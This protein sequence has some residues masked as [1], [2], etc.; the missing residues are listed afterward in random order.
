MAHR[1]QLVLGVALAMLAVTRPA[2][3]APPALAPSMIGEPPQGG[4]VFRFPQAVAL[5]PGGGTVWI[6]DE[7][8]GVVQS[9]D[10]TGTPRMT[11]GARATRGERGRFGVIG[12]LATDRSGRV[13]VLDAE[14]DRV[15]VL[16]GADGRVLAS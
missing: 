13:Y 2:A 9:F 3:A 7:Y 1:W 5:S 15:Q 4:A 16:S 11:V 14:N 8:S 10:A 12:G 6:A